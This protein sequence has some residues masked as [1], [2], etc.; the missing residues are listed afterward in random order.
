MRERAVK[1]I[2]GDE[3]KVGTEYDSP[4]SQ[5]VV[6]V[7]SWEGDEHVTLHLDRAGVR[8]LRKALKRGARELDE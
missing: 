7:E 3:V 6:T 5:R 4:K 1:D 8:K 2:W